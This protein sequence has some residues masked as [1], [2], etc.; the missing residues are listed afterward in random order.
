MSLEKFDQ[1]Q[2]PVATADLSPTF[3][4]PQELIIDIL[5]RL[6]TKSIGKLRLVSKPWHSLLY[7]PLFIKAHLAFHL[8]DQEKLIIVSSSSTPAFQYFTIN[9]ST[10]TFPSPNNYVRISQKLNR[11]LENTLSSARIVGSCNGLVLV[12]NDGLRRREFSSKHLLA[13][14][15]MY[16]VNPTTKER[17][18]LPKGPF[19]LVVGN[20]G[21]AFGYDSFNDDYKIIWPYGGTTIRR[22][23]NFVIVFSLR[24]GTCRRLYNCSYAPTTHSGVFLNG[25]VHWLAQSRVDESQVIAALDLSTEEFKQVPWP[26]AGCST[27]NWGSLASSKQLVV[28][29]GCLAMVVE[30][31]S[32]QMDIWMMKDYGV[33]ESWT[34]FGVIIPKVVEHYYKPI[35]LLGEDDV[36]LDKNGQNLV[37]HNLR[38][39]TTREILV[40]GINRDTSR[41]VGCFLESLVSPT[42]YS[43]KWRATSF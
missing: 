8:D 5:L 30:Q 6:P 4:L 20:A 25:S 37:V 38:D 18:R 19:N 36:V 28:L 31:S 26:S 21:V 39:G 15:T 24:N 29:G 1:T 12:A 43:Q 40:A 13:L 2:M 16:L 27:R 9:F 23:E 22:S 11:L 14:D 10:T 7:D 42:F 33:G 35:C 32:Q 3:P 41:D 34:K 17:L